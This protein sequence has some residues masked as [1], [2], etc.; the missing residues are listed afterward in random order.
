MY[1]L[2]V[3]ELLKFSLHPCRKW[4][5]FVGNYLDKNYDD[6]FRCGIFDG[7]TFKMSI[8][9]SKGKNCVLFYYLVYF[10]AKSMDVL[11][12]VQAWL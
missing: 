9:D 6:N 10:S 8:F 4:L 11:L 12:R 3:T 5:F 7:D 1:N 2:S